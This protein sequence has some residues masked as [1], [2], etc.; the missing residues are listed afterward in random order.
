MTELKNITYIMAKEEKGYKGKAKRSG[1]LETILVKT[2]GLAIIIAMDFFTI[3]G[4]GNILVTLFPE[5]MNADPI[6]PLIVVGFVTT[7][8]YGSVAGLLA[9]LL[10]IK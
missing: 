7:A 8:V 4:I 10:H 9:D 2:F 3:I 1:K 5:A 6:L